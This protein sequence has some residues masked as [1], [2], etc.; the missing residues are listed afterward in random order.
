[1]AFAEPYPAREPYARR[2]PDP[3]YDPDADFAAHVS[4][5]RAFV[6]YTL[7]FTAHVA[8]ILALMAYFLV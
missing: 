2:E 4:T 3:A 6:R 1:M 8:V 5:Y 7:L